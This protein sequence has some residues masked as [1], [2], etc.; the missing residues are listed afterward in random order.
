MDEFLLRHCRDL[1]AKAERESCYVYSGFLSLAERQELLDVMETFPAPCTFFGG[2]DGAE[3]TIARFGSFDYEEA[4]PLCCLKISPLNPRFADALTHR[5]FLGS[6]LALGLER[7]TLGDIVVRENT[8]YVFCLETV[9]PVLLREL[10]KVRHTRVSCSRFDG[11]VAAYAQTESLTVQ[12]ASPRLD[13]VL[14]RVYALSR[15]DAAACVAG[16]AVFLNGRLCDRAEKLL[17]AGDVVSVR[18][19]GRF[20][21]VEQVGVTK[22][23][24]C[25]LQIE[26]YV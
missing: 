9:S 13:S 19:K 15:A 26:R 21:C 2:M 12:V 7:T 17:A 8:G 5:D 18:G 3:R 20:R 1:A 23:G 25:R 6:I 10:V 14:A 4:F 24:K 11:A 22:K 16:K